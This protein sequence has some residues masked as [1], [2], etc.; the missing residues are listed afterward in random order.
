MQQPLVIGSE[1]G[2]TRQIQIATDRTVKLPCLIK[3]QTTMTAFF[4]APTREVRKL[5]P[6]KK[7]RLVELFKGQTLVGFACTEYRQVEGLDDYREVGIMVP[8][9]YC[10]R[11]DVPVLPIM[12]PHLFKDAGYYFHRMPLTSPEA[13]E[14]GLKVHGLRKVLGDIHFE[15][16][17]YL[18]RCTVDIE[19]KRLLE[20]EVKKAKTRFQKMTTQTFTYMDGKILRTPVPTQGEMGMS[21]GSASAKLTLGDHWMADEL[22]ALR[23]S[24]KPLFAMYSSP[25]QSVLA[26]PA[27]T[28]PA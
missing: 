5:L 18:R 1:A 23:L 24:R 28:F 19:G 8:V 25:V 21:N 15:D 11:F 12:A 6:S 2:P 14:V 26:A 16:Q 3:D 4:R 22:R 20:L 9:R 17:P 10:P 13:Y 27:E 7:L